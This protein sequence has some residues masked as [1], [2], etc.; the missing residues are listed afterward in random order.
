MSRTTC[1][2]CGAREQKRRETGGEGGVRGGAWG[3]S[4]GTL[5]PHADQRPADGQHQHFTIHVIITCI[6]EACALSAHCSTT[7]HPHLRQRQDG[8]LQRLRKRFASCTA[9]ARRQKA[10]R[11][12]WP[13][14]R[15]REGANAQV[16]QWMERGQLLPHRSPR[17]RLGRQASL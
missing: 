6:C 1:A 16:R 13:L 11:K 14:L 12:T 5:A 2:V 9:A 15:R 17:L 4:H 3:G 7:A 8:E 10:I